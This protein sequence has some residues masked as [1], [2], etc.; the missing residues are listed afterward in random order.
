MNFYSTYIGLTPSVGHLPV[1]R[2]PATF[3]SLWAGVNR[4]STDNPDASGEESDTERGQSGAGSCHGERRVEVYPGKEAVVAFD[5]ELTFECVE[6]CT[7]CCHH[8]VMLYEQDLLELAGVAPLSEATT[9]FRGTDFVPKEE[10]DHDHTGPDGQA[11]YFLQEDGLCALHDEHDWKPA[12]CSV[13][14][15]S[16]A[17]EDGDIHVSVRDSAHEHC[18][19]LNV[20]DRRVVD[21]L[22]AFLPELLW[23]LDDPET[24]REL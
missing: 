7:W 17:V 13:F 12:R 16:V 8:G 20:T 22:D 11:C 6:G 5:P 18:E 21:H 10:K 1:R 24:R 14:P 15:L 4:V 23:D 3:L 2:W 19:G 9:Q